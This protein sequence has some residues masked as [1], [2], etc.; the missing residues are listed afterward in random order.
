VKRR[1]SSLVETVMALALVGLLVY[2]GAVS[3][4]GLI[5]KFRL[6]S[7]V[8]AVTT[9]LNRA[10]FKAIWRGEAS[11]ISFH[12]SGF[13]QERRDGAEGTWR[14]E[15]AVS[16]P[17]VAIQANNSPVFHPAGT[18]S[19]LASITVSNRRGSY[20]ISVAISGR[21]RAVKTG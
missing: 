19:D 6:Q 11:R 8:W 18:V 3:V 7:A 12:A 13:V 14:T 5:P 16:L 10:R 20:R 4:Q 1:G 15:W 9:G 2:A 17:G 21:I